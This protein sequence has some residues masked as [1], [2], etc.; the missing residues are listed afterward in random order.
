MVQVTRCLWGY[1]LRAH[2]AGTYGAWETAFPEQDADLES[3][4]CTPLKRLHRWLAHL[5]LSPDSA[6]ESVRV[7]KVPSRL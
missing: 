2:G 7:T 3:D 5:L 6:P 1:R 4:H